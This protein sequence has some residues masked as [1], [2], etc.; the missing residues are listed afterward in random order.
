MHESLPGL[1]H[2][3]L[4]FH[5]T[6]SWLMVFSIGIPVRVCNQSKNDLM[7]ADNARH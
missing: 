4:Q 5:K 2:R 1:E 6:L 3:S 7:N